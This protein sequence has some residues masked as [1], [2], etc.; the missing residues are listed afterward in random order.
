M[1]KAV[2]STGRVPVGAPL[3]SRVDT[4]SDTF[5]RNRDGN[6]ELIEQFEENLAEARAGGGPEKVERHHKRGKFMIRDRIGL[7]L[8]RDSPFL[9]LQ[10]LAGWGSDFKVGGSTVQGIGVVSGVECL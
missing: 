4:D 7:L 8:D 6:L 9:E 10:Q 1:E 2:L 5:A 3:P